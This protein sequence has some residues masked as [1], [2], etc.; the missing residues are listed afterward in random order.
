M[1]IEKKGF[2]IHCSDSFL[3]EFP[4]MRNMVSAFM[5]LTDAA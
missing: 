2:K 3:A 5:S 1:C 4:S